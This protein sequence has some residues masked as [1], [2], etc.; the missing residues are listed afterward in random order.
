[1]RMSA[2]DKEN[3]FALERSHIQKCRS[4]HKKK[5][6]EKCES[7]NNTKMEFNQGNILLLVLMF[8]GGL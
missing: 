4:I 5:K 2:R 8:A 3:G 7:E 1:M 6:G